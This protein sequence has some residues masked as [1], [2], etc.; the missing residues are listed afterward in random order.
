MQLAAYM[1][2]GV[3]EDRWRI[4]QRPYEIIGDE[5]AWT[6]FRTDFLRK[7]IPTHIRD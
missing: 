4:V 6:A 1:F 5:A 7:F 3:A 2:R